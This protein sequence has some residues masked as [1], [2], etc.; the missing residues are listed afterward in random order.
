MT[1]F[2]VSA[3]SFF[4]GGWAVQWAVWLRDQRAKRLRQIAADGRLGLLGTSD[5]LSAE[6]QRAAR[7]EQLGEAGTYKTFN[8]GEILHVDYERGVLI[9]ARRGRFL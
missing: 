9:C 6:A 5:G 4:V 7:L 2:I 3:I 8:C 1:Y